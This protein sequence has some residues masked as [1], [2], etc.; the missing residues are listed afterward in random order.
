MAAEYKYKGNNSFQAM[1]VK[2]RAGKLGVKT[3]PS[4]CFHTPWQETAPNVGLPEDV[5]AM[6]AGASLNLPGESGQNGRA[7]KR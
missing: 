1:R 4:D 5:K 6:A 7:T 2:A 3:N